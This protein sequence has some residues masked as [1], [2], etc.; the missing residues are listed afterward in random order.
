[1]YNETNAFPVTQEEY[2]INRAIAKKEIIKGS[3]TM[4]LCL[5]NLVAT[6]LIGYTLFQALHTPK[7]SSVNQV[8]VS[9]QRGI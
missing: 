5:G 6:L 7:P 9:H 8:A 1:M 2:L 3:I 4:A